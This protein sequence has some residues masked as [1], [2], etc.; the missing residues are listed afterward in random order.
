MKFTRANEM[1]NLTC[2]AHANETER[3]APV[4]W[5]AGLPRIMPQDHR[6]DLG[7]HGHLME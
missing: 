6:A 3:A 2:K 5:Q 1:R 7:I 4:L